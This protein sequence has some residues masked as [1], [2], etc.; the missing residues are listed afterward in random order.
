MKSNGLLF[1]PQPF[2]C[3]LLDIFSCIYC[4]CFK[5]SQFTLAPPPPNPLCTFIF[6][7]KTRRTFYGEFSLEN[8]GVKKEESR[9]PAGKYFAEYSRKMAAVTEKRSICGDACGEKIQ[10]MPFAGEEHSGVEIFTWPDRNVFSIFAEMTLYLFFPPQFEKSLYI[11]GECIRDF[12]DLFELIK[13]TL[14]FY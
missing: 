4:L 8:F 9:Q 6:F 11:A 13:S 14:R 12:S 3:I 2:Y 7:I 5:Y 1:H 10:V